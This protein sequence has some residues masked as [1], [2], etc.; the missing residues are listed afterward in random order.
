M[1]HKGA[2]LDLYTAIHNYTTTI[3]YNCIVV[4]RI[5]TNYTQIY[6]NRYNCIVVLT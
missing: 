6:N 4:L 5:Y 3:L 2:G 1:G